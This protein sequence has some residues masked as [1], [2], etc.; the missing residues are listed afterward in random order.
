MEELARI[1]SLIYEIRG[2]KVMLDKDL[3]FN[4]QKRNGIL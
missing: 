1:K 4:S 3:C 2:V